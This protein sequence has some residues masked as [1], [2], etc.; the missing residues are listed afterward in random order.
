MSAE[1]L[2]RSL[3]VLP[4]CTGDRVTVVRGTDVTH[5]EVCSI[6][7]GIDQFGLI[8]F[9]LSFRA[10]ISLRDRRLNEVKTLLGA[11]E[12]EIRSS[13]PTLTSLVAAATKLLHETAHSFPLGEAERTVVNQVF[14]F[15]I[16][17][18]T[19]QRLRQKRQRQFLNYLPWFLC[20]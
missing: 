15:S 19:W 10:A 20:M 6:C 1:R 8:N 12:A 3:Q 14:C 2:Q 11:N 18:K 13:D 9:Q 4:A 16:N 5:S 17:K 7:V